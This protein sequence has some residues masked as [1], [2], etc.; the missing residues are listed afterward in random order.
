MSLFTNLKYE[1]NFL[2]VF[3]I[4]LIKNIAKINLLIFINIIHIKCI[5]NIIL[6]KYKSTKY[7]SIFST[8]TIT[9]FKKKS[10]WMNHMSTSPAMCVLMCRMLWPL[11]DHKNVKIR[12]KYGGVVI[13]G[14]DNFTRKRDIFIKILTKQYFFI[15][16]YYLKI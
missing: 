7:I 10:F 8:E 11:C 2:H 5:L 15:F 16:I 1:M 12:S 3:Y 14:F 4:K 6:E 13:T 9:Q